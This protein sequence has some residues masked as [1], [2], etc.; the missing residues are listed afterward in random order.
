[1]KKTTALATAAF[2]P[3]RDPNTLEMFPDLT[4]KPRKIPKTPAE[5]A[6]RHRQKKKQEEEAGQRAALNLKAPDL[7][8][9]GVALSEFRERWQRVPSKLAAVDALL[10]RVP[11]PC[12]ADAFPGDSA[13]LPDALQR[14]QGMA[15]WPAS[16]GYQA[17]MGLKD[18]MQY[19]QTPIGQ[20]EVDG[21]VLPGDT[22]WT[23]YGSGPYIV[24]EVAAQ[25][26]R[27]MR[28]FTLVLLDLGESGQRKRKREADG[29]INEVVAVDGRLLKLFAV[30]DD[31][32]FVAKRE[33]VHGYVEADEASAVRAECRRIVAEGRAAYDRACAGQQLAMATFDELAFKLLPFKDRTLL[34]WAR[35]NEQLVRDTPPEQ[36]YPADPE[37]R[38]VLGK[39]LCDKHELNGRYQVL[40]EQS[41]ELYELVDLELHTPRMSRPAE[42]LREYKRHS[43][44]YAGHVS[45][46]STKWTTERFKTFGKRPAKPSVW[47]VRAEAA[48]AELANI[49][50]ELEQLSQ[51]V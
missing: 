13:W 28:C 9:L 17:D 35:R 42:F 22:V 49:R 50:A 39:V 32:I 44:S 27:G 48:E 8:L 5:R 20:P 19:R 46:G 10:P 33:L 37:K 15:D 29:W 36:V 3:D 34:E 18:L 4:V 6:K 11:I 24:K 51:T 12:V 23:S 7:A 47:Q 31:E 30:N 25:E 14:G 1:M 43:E 38:N 16:S 40:L 41:I 45:A 21:L 2:A 26:C